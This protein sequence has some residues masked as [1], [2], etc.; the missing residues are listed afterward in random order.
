MDGNEALAALFAAATASVKPRQL[1][2]Q[3]HLPQQQQQNQPQ[4]KISKT[5]A[6]TT[7]VS[8]I[9]TTNSKKS[10]Q[11]QETGQAQAMSAANNLI[12]SLLNGSLQSSSLPQTKTTATF[13]TTTARSAASSQRKT[14]SSPEKSKATMLQ[15]AKQPQQQ[16]P[17]G[18][19]SSEIVINEIELRNLET[20]F[21]EDAEKLDESQYQEL[22]DSG[23]TNGWSADEMFKYNEKRH[24][25]MSSFNHR[26]INQCY[27]T[28]LPKNRSK[29]SVSKA[30]K[31]AAEIEERALVQGGR[32]TPESSDDDELFER[33]RLRRVQL[34]Q[35]KQLDQ[36][37][38]LSS[39]SC[40]SDKHISNHSQKRCSSGVKPT[41]NNNKL[42]YR[43][44]VIGSVYQ[45]TSARKSSKPYSQLSDS[46][47]TPPATI[48]STSSSPKPSDSSSA[49][50]NNNVTKS[51]KRNIFRTSLS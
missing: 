34:K 26:T 36:L 12:A 51:S 21:D 1:Q 29:L 17:S 39:P 13:T 14:S 50:M 44:P 25:I 42:D 35:Q 38:N 16:Q 6:K 7:P 4:Q 41:S 5:P 49:N 45:T 19:S 46:S 32:V 27:T 28:P 8:A 9:K 31:L 40:A 15:Q 18:S 47:V 3:Q 11:S 48:S 43:S 23:E 10:S 33:E 20:W 24:K 22:A 2:Q 30:T 37:K